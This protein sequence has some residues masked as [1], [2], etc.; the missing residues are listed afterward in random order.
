VGAPMDF[1]SSVFSAL[2]A[3]EHGDTEEE[4]AETEKREGVQEA[5]VREEESGGRW[6]F[7]RLIQ[8]LKEETEEQRRA[9]EVVQVAQREASATEVEAEADSGDGWIFSNLIKTLAEEIGAQRKE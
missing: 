9:Q 5:E 8:M 1:F 6:I 4:E 3:A 2:V 7:D